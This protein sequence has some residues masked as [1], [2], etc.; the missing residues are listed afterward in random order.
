MDAATNALLTDGDTALSLP[1]FARIKPG[2]FQ[3]A[4]ERGMQLHREELARIAAD[5]AAPDFANTVAAFDR[6]GRLLRLNRGVLT[7]QGR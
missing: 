3:P 2:H 7:E 4:I 1:A 6:C 5:P